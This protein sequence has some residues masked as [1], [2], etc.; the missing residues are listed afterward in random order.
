ME[1]QKTEQIQEQIHKDM[2]MGEIIRKYPGAAE[3]MQTHGLHCFGC[4]VSTWETL[5]Q[6][7]M[8]HG[9]NEQSVQTLVHEIN[10]FIK[11]QSF[12]DNK[13]IALTTKAAEKLK[14]ILKQYPAKKGLRIEIAE[15]GCAGFSYNF[16]LVESPHQE[17]KIIEQLGVQV[18]MNEE[19]LKLMNGAKIDYVEALQ[20][21][22]FKVSN[23]HATSTCGCGQ[24][25][26]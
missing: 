19:S 20:G 17:E 22:G 4:H 13:E 14:E 21:A 25:F 26:S 1:I 18:Y 8:G 2:T 9:G 10:E 7:I 12:A 23:P 3:V 11:N 24:S 16:S 6:G 5:E 15:G